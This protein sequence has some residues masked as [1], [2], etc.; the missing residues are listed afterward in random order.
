MA[1]SYSG[2]IDLG[3]INLLFIDLFFFTTS[4]LSLIH[5]HLDFYQY[6]RK[7]K[8][9]KKS[10]AYIIIIGIG[11]YIYFYIGL[12]FFFHIDKNSSD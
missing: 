1:T 8:Q 7:Q 4:L 11:I 10:Y 3:V 6:K 2:T 12:I 5:S 9:L